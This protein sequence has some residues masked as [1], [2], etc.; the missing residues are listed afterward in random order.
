MLILVSLGLSAT[1][2]EIKRNIIL[3]ASY[4]H[5]KF[6]NRKTA[7]GDKFSQ[8]KL[9]GAYNGVALNTKVKVTRIID[10]DTYHVTV[11]INDR[12]AN[13]FSDRIDLSKA[14]A[15]KIHLIKDGISEVTVTPQEL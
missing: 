3:T 4:Y 6:Q 9:T 12:T 10:S 14:A 2:N 8:N 15:K 13:R 7:N 11:I 1:E 5:D